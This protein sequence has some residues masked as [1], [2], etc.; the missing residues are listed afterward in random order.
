MPVSLETLEVSISMWYLL[1]SCCNVVPQ[2]VN[3]L[4]D[5]YFLRVIKHTH[6]PTHTH[7]LTHTHKHTHSKV[8]LKMFLS[9]EQHNFHPLALFMEDVRYEVHDPFPLL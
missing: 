6:T 9:D 7:T 5:K 1:K 2:L 8:E 3:F 4:F